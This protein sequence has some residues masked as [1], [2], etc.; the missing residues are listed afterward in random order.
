ML[1]SEI[2]SPY[3][4]PKEP[5]DVYDCYFCYFWNLDNFCTRAH[6][7]STQGT[8]KE[9]VNPVAQNIV[10]LFCVATWVVAILGWHIRSTVTEENVEKSMSYFA[11]AQLLYGLHGVFSEKEQTWP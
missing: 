1:I 4:Y 3:G 9:F 8:P 5:D 2:K 7:M 6:I 10:M 11:I